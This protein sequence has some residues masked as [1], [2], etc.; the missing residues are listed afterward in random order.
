M[1]KNERVNV[2]IGVTKHLGLKGDM[3]YIRIDLGT[4]RDIGEDEDIN[5]VREQ[6]F[7]E[8]LSL[9]EQVIS[10]AQDELSG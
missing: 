1:A 5:D 9:M 4:D 2:K 7:A 10:L 3:E 6:L 8:Q